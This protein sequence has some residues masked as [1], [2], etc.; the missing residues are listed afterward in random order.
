MERFL[1]ALQHIQGYRVQEHTSQQ[2]HLWIEAM[3]ARPSSQFASP[4]EA[5]LLSAFRYL[6]ACLLATFDLWAVHLDQDL[7]LN[8]C[9]S[10]FC[11]M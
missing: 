10:W 7:V 11:G 2:L 8:K 9:L 5:S 4:D 1:L 3:K 6:K